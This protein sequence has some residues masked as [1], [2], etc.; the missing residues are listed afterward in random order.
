MDITI[1]TFTIGI[2]TY[3]F[4]RVVN[5][6]NKMKPIT[7][8]E[9]DKE[10]LNKIEKL[11]GQRL[12]YR[13]PNQR[14]L[15]F[16]IIELM[17]PG[18][19]KR[20]I[21]DQRGHCHYLIK[22]HLD[23]SIFE[24]IE[25]GL[26]D[27]HY[28]R[29]TYWN[30]SKEKA[31][32]YYYGHRQVSSLAD[33]KTKLQYYGSMI[34]E[35]KE[36]LV[37]LEDDLKQYANEVENH[38][39]CQR[40]WVKRGG[41]TDTDAVHSIMQ[42]EKI[43]FSKKQDLRRALNVRNVLRISAINSGF[44]TY[45]KTVADFQKRMTDLHL[46][47]I[48]SLHQMDIL[49]KRD[50]RQA[51]NLLAG[52][53]AEE[54]VNRKVRQ[55]QSGKVLLHNLILPYPYEKQ[56]SL[57]SNQIDHLVIAS[58]GIFCIETKAR[59]TSAGKYNALTDYDE[60]ADQVAKHKESIKY[61]LNKSNNPIIIALLK[62]VNIDQLIRNIVVF[63]SRTEKDFILEKTERYQKVGIEVAQLADLQSLFVQAKANF[64]LYDEEISAIENEL[65]DYNVLSNE[66]VYSTNVLL[67]DDSHLS[68]QAINEQLYHAN[69]VIKHIN[70][71]NKL[72]DK[73]LTEARK[74]QKQYKHYRYWRKFYQQVRHFT[75]TDRY[76]EK[77]CIKKDIF[78][79]I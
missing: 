14:G 30:E 40:E 7:L 42:A 35:G 46:G 28:F 60:L 36:I 3:C 64:G 48:K 52:S 59:S 17:R 57:D 38:A 65:T 24:I 27:G 69:Q 20:R 71:I 41:I 29:K 26:T 10:E 12:P 47:K 50:L 70:H 22:Y 45:N 53:A 5:A 1:I 9:I 4:F 78:D 11:A 63:V 23:R 62:R 72:L 19:I 51:S 58:S 8:S 25:F 21:F 33:V 44:N 32:F 79:E 13:F 6:K 39:T 68:Q 15:K 67:F 54:L 55:V 2:L 76:Y 31:E 34:R 61:V 43:S 66:K 49:S 77:H 75:N 37:P 18:Y 74:W 16:Q 73:Y 56:D